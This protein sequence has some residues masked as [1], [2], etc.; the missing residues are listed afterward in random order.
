MA[1]KRFLASIL[2][3][4]I[5]AVLFLPFYTNLYLYPA[6]TK[7][8]LADAEYSAKQL[9]SHLINY[10]V[11]PENNLGYEHITNDVMDEIDEML[12]DFGC[13]KVKIF[14]P[15]GEI[16]YST[17]PD[18]IGSVNTKEYFK[19]V[20]TEGTDFTT[21]VNKNNLTAEGKTV[22]VDVIETYVPLRF[23]ER[24][25]GASEVYFE[26]TEH[27]KNIELLVRHS[28]LIVIFITSILLI[29]VFITLNRLN[30]SMIAR[31]QAEK[32]LSSH[33]DHLEDLV[34]ERTAELQ[35]TNIQLQADIKKRR[36]AEKA[37]RE[38]EEKYRGLIETAS[39]AIIVIDYESGKIIDINR[40]GLELLGRSAHEI[41]GMHHSQIHPSDETEKYIWLFRKFVSHLSLPDITYHIL[42]KD[43]T[44]IPVE[45]S[46]SIMELE[47]R[48][49]IQGIFRDLREKI[50]FEEEI[51]KAQRLESAGVLAG[52]MAHDFNN[53][54][55]SI[56]GNIS[57][58]KAFAGQ[59]EKVYKRLAETEKAV[60]RAKNL[61]QQL[62]TFAKG[63]FPLTR[64]VD[65]SNT[66][67]ESAEFALRG[68]KL[69]CEYQIAQN[70]WP[71]E[72]DPGQI[73]QVIHNLVINAY[74]S[75]PE[76][77]SCRL[78]AKNV[79][80]R[81]SASIPLPE[82]KYV[83]I[84]VHDNGSGIP[85]EHLNKIFDPFFT[86]K[87]SGTGLGL[88]TA[89]SIIKKHG[90]ILSVDSEVGKGSIF[91]IFLPVSDK[92][93]L[94]AN[95]DEAQPESFKGSGKVLLMDD[96]KFL[97]EMVSELLQHL[98]YSV[99]TA[100]DGIEAL[101]LYKKGIESGQKYAAVIMDL[102]I[103]GGMGGKE[104]IRELKKI[105]PE[106]K[107]IVSSGYANDPI[108]ANFKDYGFDAILPKPYE[109]E[110]LAKTLH[111][112]IHQSG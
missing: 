55:T 27:R 96:E 76:G 92:A 38:S 37:L 28:S 40:K 31:E 19:P 77:G 54:L 58:A 111:K 65:L 56:L 95:G 15:S 87:R 84:S 20:V 30:K 14:A 88:P 22:A 108:L 79:Q 2:L 103:P 51:Q 69:K 50:K 44:R 21:I 7:H 26:I 43:G 9:A 97:L 3:I 73:N 104:T 63:G 1:R 13:E 89:Y 105:D 91:H 29:A 25:V 80:I 47:G 72:A 39:E 24:I 10:I 23:G 93:V 42:H 75:L 16:L 98:G 67:V 61:T 64:T 100:T 86:T 70:L 83:N 112:V 109:V 32:E 59:N 4:S 110:E 62:L 36:L 33:R 85:P 101:D 102:T 11:E 12:S 60:M 66:V 49:I 46:T 90:G 5:I 41:I 35:E 18:E 94:T 53:L 68:A 17:D 81:D 34:N 71:V 6:F 57:L 45:I 82:G 48:K 52:G 78:E 106:A 8:L 99:D 107:T 74:Q